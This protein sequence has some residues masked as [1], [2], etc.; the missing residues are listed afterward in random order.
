MIEHVGI[1]SRSLVVGVLVWLNSAGLTWSADSYQQQVQPFFNQF[2]H[3]CHNSRETRGELDLSRYR[4]SGDVT[5]AFRRFSHV[6][7]FIRNAEMPPSDASKQPTPE[8]R[9]AVVRALKAI[10]AEEAKKHAGDPGT[11]LP[12]RLSNTEYD[13]SVRDLTGVDIQPTKTFPAD[14]AAGEGFDNTGE[15]LAMSPS[16]LKKYLGAAQQVS[17]HLVLKPNGVVFAPFPVTSYN[18]RKKLT[19]QAIIDFYERNHVEVLDYLT[20][21]WRYRHRDSS[22][23]N[24]TIH[25]WAKQNGLSPKYLALVWKTL[26]EAKSGTGHLKQVGEVW[27]TIPPPRPGDKRPD[28]LLELHRLIEFCRRNLCHREEGLIRSNAGNWPISHLDF[29]AKT[30]AVRDQFD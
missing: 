13:L 27:A 23:R 3:S 17:E 11:V 24:L 9:T 6:I 15:A 2:C 14:P 10:L 25:Q 16:L 4:V 29:R 28:A 30:A 8:Q 18:E 1:R 22:E 26:N 5:R 21:A 7:E 20:A 19:E 12:R